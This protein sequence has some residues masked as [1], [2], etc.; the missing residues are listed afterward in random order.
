[1][2]A[3]QAE[4]HE[5]DTPDFTVEDM[6]GINDSHDEV[7]KYDKSPND[8]SEHLTELDQKFATLFDKTISFT[9][10]QN[11]LFDI[12]G[13][14]EKRCLDRTS[15]F[16]VLTRE[17]KALVSRLEAKISLLSR[18]LLKTN[19]R[20]VNEDDILQSMRSEISDNRWIFELKNI[21]MLQVK[22]SCI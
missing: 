5:R 2:K 21:D 19:N 12:I 7:E 9:S 8:A 13:M 10:S 11:F 20:V 17:A 22:R 3:N 14:R 6:E 1:M 18:S 16:K 4:Q 15:R